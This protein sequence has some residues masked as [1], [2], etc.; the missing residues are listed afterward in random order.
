[1]DQEVLKHLGYALNI[2]V[3][4]KILQKHETKDNQNPN[5]EQTNEKKEEIPELPSERIK[6]PKDRSKKRKERREKKLV[7]IKKKINVGN[8][9]KTKAE[10]CE[11]VKERIRE[12]IAEFVKLGELCELYFKILNKRNDI[13]ESNK[14]KLYRH[15]TKSATIIRSKLEVLTDYYSNENKIEDFVNKKKKN[16][17]EISKRT[18]NEKRT[19]GL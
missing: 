1:M 11:E 16:S 19:K 8:Q 13:S 15:V 3:K 17:S 2:T 9:F 5:Q 6:K 14:Q 10:M 4:E 12:K 7:K 18:L